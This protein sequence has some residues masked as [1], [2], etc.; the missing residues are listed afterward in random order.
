MES[1][2]T[3]ADTMMKAEPHEEHRWLEKL[4]GEWTYEGEAPTE[5]GKPP[6]KFSGTETVRSLG[7]LW[8]VAEGRGPA[9]GGEEHTT[10]AALGYD[11]RKGTYVGT[12]IGSM[13][14]HMWVYERGD[15]DATQQVLTL[16]AEGPSMSGDGKTARY[17]DVIEFNGDDERTLTGNVLGDDG[18]WQP[19]MS[20]TYRRKR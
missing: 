10:L 13:M 20:M 8:F 9:P 7:G 12:W 15:V 6:E 3:P 5:P 4:V 1:N 19:M 16:E 11:P 18:T 2:S 14:T 17:R